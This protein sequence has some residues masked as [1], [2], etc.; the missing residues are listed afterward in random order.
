VQSISLPKNGAIKDIYQCQ[1]LR[2]QMIRKTGTND[3]VARQYE[4]ILVL[5]DSIAS[6]DDRLETARIREILESKEK[7]AEITSLKKE[8]ALNKELLQKQQKGSALGVIILVLMV[9]LVIMIVVILQLSSKR[10]ADLQLKI[11]ER[12]KAIEEAVESNRLKTVFMGTLSHEVRT[13]L[14][15]IQG[16]VE[17][18]EV[19]QLNEL[20]RQNYLRIIKRRANDPFANIIDD[21]NWRKEV[22]RNPLFNYMVVGI[23][24]GKDVDVLAGFNYSTMR[25]NDNTSKF[26]LSFFII[27]S[28]GKLAIQIEYDVNLYTKETVSFFLQQIKNAMTQIIMNQEVILRDISFND[29]QFKV[30]K[31]SAAII[32]E[33]LVL[34]EMKVF[35]A[36]HVAAVGDVETKLFSIW[37]ENLG[38]RD[39]G[40]TDNFFDIGGTSMKAIRL[41]NNINVEFNTTLT[42]VDVFTHSNIRSFGNFILDRRE[43][44]QPQKEKELGTTRHMDRTLQLVNN[45]K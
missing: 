10:N 45:K 20:Q 31:D 15:G 22:D 13:P 42:I 8:S 33:N 26:D 16:V 6:M 4:K 11:H 5:K 35:Q 28:D 23:E 40:V 39:F 18:M 17:L 1:L 37:V 44:N 24:H 21:L 32:N 41:I 29:R 19:P 25:H 7:E 2:V 36:H 27:N 12:D 14:Q 30:K 43:L 38:R 34:Q 3:A 9:C